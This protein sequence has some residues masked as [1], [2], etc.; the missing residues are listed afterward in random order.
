MVDLLTSEL[1]AINQLVAEAAD[2][3]QNLDLNIVQG[4]VAVI[5]GVDMLAQLTTQAGGDSESSGVIGFSLTTDPDA[6]DLTDWEAGGD[7]AVAIEAAGGGVV[8]V[9]PY[10]FQVD[11]LTSGM[12]V[13]VPQ[14]ARWDWRGMDVDRRPSTTEITRLLHAV[15]LSSTDIDVRIQIYYQIAR[16][17]P[18]ELGRFPLGQRVLRLPSP[19]PRG[20]AGP[21]GRVL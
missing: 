15:S 13:A 4:N 18:T 8:A 3:V 21:A 20:T 10:Q 6:G 14:R 16:L 11:L 2:G 17:T 7:V 5:N 12:Y 9:F 1:T 19:E